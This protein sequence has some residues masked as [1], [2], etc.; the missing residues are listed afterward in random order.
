MGRKK[1]QREDVVM[2]RMIDSMCDNISML[3]L[4][5]G[6][7]PGTEI[8]DKTFHD[9]MSKIEEEIKVRVIKRIREVID[10]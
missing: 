5:M 9:M 1:K 10:N 3:L 2:K 8:F 4:E 6:F 7:Y